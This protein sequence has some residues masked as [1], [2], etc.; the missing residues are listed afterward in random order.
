MFINQVQEGVVL[1]G[2]LGY[3]HYMVP[4]TF[5]SAITEEKVYRLLWTKS[6]YI[7]DEC[8]IVHK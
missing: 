4:V 7:T 8:K 6:K 2:Q 5:K 1:T 3:K